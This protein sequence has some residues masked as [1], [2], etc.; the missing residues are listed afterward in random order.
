[1]RHT[2]DTTARRPGAR[3]ARARGTVSVEA[4]FC[5]IVLLFFLL[6]SP[7]LWKMWINEN[8][9]RHEAERQTFRLT[10]SFIDLNQY[11]VLGD[12]ILSGDFQALLFGK[13]PEAADI[14]DLDPEPPDDLKGFEDF[15]NKV[16]IGDSK[17]EVYYSSGWKDF[18]GNFE[19]RRYSYTLRPT[20]TWHA[21]PFVHT[22]DFI[23]QG[24]VEDWFKEAYE[25]TLDDDTIEGLA[26]NGDIP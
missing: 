23:E 2:T 13:K 22:Q 24:K 7:A 26:L 17:R 6:M 15:S 20:W 25:A 5:L 12:Q 8:I 21:Y 11:Q 10:S 14:P 18:R 9:A 4:S 16:V 1:M 3:S 19:I